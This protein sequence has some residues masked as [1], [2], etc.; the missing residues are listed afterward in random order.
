M[1]AIRP[2]APTS[3][4]SSCAPGI[5][6]AVLFALPA[7]YPIATAAPATAVAAANVSVPVVRAVASVAVPVSDMQRSLSF[8]HDVLGFEAAYE[9]LY[10]VF[11]ARVRI[12]TLQLGDEQLQLE[13]FIAPAGRS[14]PEDSRSNDGWFQHVAIIVSDL[15]RAYA[16]LRAHQVRHGS[17][18]PQLLPQWNVNAA[19]IGAFYFRDPDGHNL[20]VLHFPPGKGSAKWQDHPERLFLGIDHTAIVVADTEASLKYYRDALGLKIAGSSENFGV[21]QEHLNNVFGARLRITA[22]RAA[23]GPG[24]ELLEYLAP[25]TGRQM[26]VDTLAN[27]LWSWHV[28]MQADVQR[29]DAAVRAQH[30]SYVSPGPVQLDALTPLTGLLLRDPDGHATL[31]LQGP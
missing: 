13:Q 15:D 24:V 1:P 30:F 8:Y 4:L 2:P 25:R 28:T 6:A 7:L 11:G 26:P 19:G 27:D 16:L 20:E 21:E 31:L 10:G 5:V 3:G 12:V 23:L 14:I 9:H 18:G 29:A 22:L 17:T